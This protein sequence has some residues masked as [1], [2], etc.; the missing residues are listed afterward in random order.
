MGRQVSLLLFLLVA[1]I[2]SGFTFFTQQASKTAPPAARKIAPTQ[3][4]PP[5]SMSAAACANGDAFAELD[6]QQI[7]KDGNIRPARKCGFCFG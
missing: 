4:M 1:A 5:T 2:A 7:I 6:N 3:S